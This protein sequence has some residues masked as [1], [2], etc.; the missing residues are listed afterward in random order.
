LTASAT[1]NLVRQERH[2][3]HEANIRRRSTN[4]SRYR[5][6]EI[7]RNR[8]RR[9]KAE[10]NLSGRITNQYHLHV[11]LR[12]QPCRGV[13]VATHGD[14]GATLPLCLSQVGTCKPAIHTH[15]PR[16]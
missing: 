6:H 12:D 16:K 8:Q 4:G 3:G 5:D 2:I 13:V 1:P 10:H 11:C 14:Y 9:I 7:H 15:I